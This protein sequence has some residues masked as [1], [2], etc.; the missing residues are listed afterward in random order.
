[1]TF[2]HPH[3]LALALLAPAAA[4]VAALLWRRRRAATEAW[5]ARGLWGRLLEGWVPSRIGSR[6]GPR[7]TLSVLCLAIGVLGTTLALAQPRWGTSEET[8]EREGVDVVYVVDTSLSMGAGDA[9]PSRLA[10]AR[11]LVRRLIRAMPGNRVALVGAEGDGAVLT[12]L[13]TDA[14]VVDL[15]LDGLEPGSLPTP[16]TELG[17]ALDRVPDLFPPGSDHHRAVVLLSDGEDHGGG[18]EPRVQALKDAGVVV[19]TVGIG[20][21]RGAPVPV[22]VAAPRADGRRAAGGSEGVKRHE[23]G[24]VVISTLRQEVLERMARATGGVYLHAIDGGRSLR[25]L[26]A[27]LGTMDRH[28]FETTTMDTRAE[29]FQWPL[30]AAAIALLLHLAVPP[31]RPLRTAGPRGPGAGRRSGGGSTTGRGS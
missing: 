16:G 7:I 13:T 26:V 12:P 8:V 28:V 20:T 29:R 11:T 18:L 24:S 23:D 4:W 25:P 22:G 2:A 15:I 31:F 10:V 1:M 17:H 3:L 6:A 14:A 27:A 5:A 21:R 30:A 9:P 19:H